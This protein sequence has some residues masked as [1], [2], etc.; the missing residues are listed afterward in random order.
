MLS[1]T[2][3]GIG[4]GSRGDFKRFKGEIYDGFRTRGSEVIGDIN[5]QISE[6]D[7]KIKQQQDPQ[8]VGPKSAELL[9]QM[10]AELVQG[11]DY[12]MLIQNAINT[13]PENVTNE[14]LDLVIKKNELIAQ[15]N[16]EDVAFKNVEEINK[17]N[18]QIQNSDVVAIT[19]QNFERTV[20]NTQKIVD[21]INPSLGKRKIQFTS[22][23]GDNS[24]QDMYNFLV[25]ETGLDLE[26]A[27]ETIGSHGGAFVA[28]GIEYIVINKPVSLSSTGA[29][30]AAH[31][32]L[33]KMM[34]M[35]MAERDS[36]GDLITDENN[37]PVINK[38][39]SMAL[40]QGLGS[41]IMGIDANKV[42]NSIFAQRLKA[43]QQAPSSVQ[44]QEVLTLFSDALAT[45]DIKFEEGRFE[46]VGKFLEKAYQKIGLPVS[47]GD[48][49]NP[50][51]K[52]KTGKDVF[53]FLKSFNESI[54]KGSLTADQRAMFI[55]G[56]SIEG[57]LA[58]LTLDKNIIEEATADRS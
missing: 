53:N 42:E 19:K 49:K 23:D 4:G 57:E 26:T 27:Q 21:A 37:Q 33:H 20:D 12:A 52:L 22:F 35:T 51:V 3:K 56:A 47:F 29:N 15:Q 44:A 45:G 14:Q 18:E 25:G 7:A 50:G 28:N 46:K 32:L 16:K 43:Y 30:V 36:K 11:R 34:F 8:Y 17:I 38:E 39:T 54:K 24:T 41:Y 55:E 40:A 5:S 48:S 10:K 31:E 13:S 6:I 1:G 9:E 2:L 58:D